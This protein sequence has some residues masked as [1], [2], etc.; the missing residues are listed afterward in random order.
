MVVGVLADSDKGHEMAWW[1]YLAG[2]APLLLMG[3]FSRVSGRKPAQPAAQIGMWV[4][5][6]F[7]AV[8]G[9][10]NPDGWPL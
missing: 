4:L 6:L 3:V 9:V 10:F 8:Q 1:I 5:V 2:W 7:G